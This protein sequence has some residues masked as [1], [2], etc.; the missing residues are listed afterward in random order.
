MLTKMLE[1]RIG[2][3]IVKTTVG[4]RKREQ[5][6]SKQATPD[7]W[8]MDV[9]GSWCGRYTGIWLELLGSNLVTVLLH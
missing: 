7:E 5:L 1:I 9:D 6:A 3:E 2:R 8:V 4:T